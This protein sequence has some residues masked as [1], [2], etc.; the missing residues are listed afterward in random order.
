MKYFII[1]FDEK[2]YPVIRM[3]CDRFFSKGPAI[4]LAVVKEFRKED[5]EWGKKNPKLWASYT[6]IYCG[7][8]G[9]VIYKIPER[10]VSLVKSNLNELRELDIVSDFRI[11]EL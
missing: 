9:E 3:T 5:P 8:D 10:Y 4:L 7:K 11:E 1:N 6:G 2:Y